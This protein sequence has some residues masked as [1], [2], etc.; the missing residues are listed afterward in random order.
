MIVN[1][2]VII[3]LTLLEGFFVVVRRAIAIVLVVVEVVLGVRVDEQPTPQ[4][5]GL[6]GRRLGRE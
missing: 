2:L 4:H 5:L 6:P 3:I 1:I